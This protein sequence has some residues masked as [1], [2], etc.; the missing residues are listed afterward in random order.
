MSCAIVAHKQ[1]SVCQTFLQEY[2]GSIFGA[3][4]FD[5]RKRTKKE[6]HETTVS[7]NFQIRMMPK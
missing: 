7:Q 4:K 2:N 3:I 5:R 6:Q 1:E